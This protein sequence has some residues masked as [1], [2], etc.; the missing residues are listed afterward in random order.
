MYRRT[1]PL[2][3]TKIVGEYKESAEH[4]RS[5]IGVV[6]EIVAEKKIKTES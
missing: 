2:F 3:A 6:T 5:G 4:F 1:D